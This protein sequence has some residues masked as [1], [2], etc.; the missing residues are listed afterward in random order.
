MK[1]FLFA[2]SFQFL[3]YSIIYDI[4]KKVLKDKYVAEKPTMTFYRMLSAFLH[5]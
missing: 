4:I 5:Y 1:T 2:N 3:I